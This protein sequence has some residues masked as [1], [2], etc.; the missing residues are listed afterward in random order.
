MKLVFCAF[1]LL[2]LVSSVSGQIYGVRWML[3]NAFGVDRPTSEKYV[4]MFNADVKF[5]GRVELVFAR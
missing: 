5:S 1:C 4:L 2:L 3:G